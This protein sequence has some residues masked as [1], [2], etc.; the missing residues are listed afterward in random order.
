[1]ERSLIIVV[2]LAFTQLGCASQ[3]VN[4]C[5]YEAGSDARLTGAE[6]TL[7][8]SHPPKEFFG[9][10]W[11]ERIDIPELKTG[12]FTFSYPLEAGLQSSVSVFKVGYYPATADLPLKALPETYNLSVSLKPKRKPISLIAF[13]W[14]GEDVKLAYK[15]NK[16][17]KQ[18]DCLKADWL[19]PDGEGL[20]ADMEFSL[21]RYRKGTK[22]YA[23]FSIRFTNPYDGFEE[24]REYYA[25][26]MRIREAPTT[27]NLQNQL[28]FIEE[29]H[30]GF[31]THFP[32]LKNYAFRVRTQRTP[33]GELLSAYY[34]KLYN[35][36]TFNYVKDYWACDFEYYLNPTPNDRNLE[37]NGHSVNRPRERIN[38]IR[39][40]R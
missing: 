28:D 25:D 14:C 3:N 4:L 9:S 13:N 39:H 5:V 1:M 22:T 20:K 35:A 19:P 26:R 32:Q 18:Y 24:V 30:D 23:W 12:V 15:E 36:F 34:G 8:V 21:Q 29:L 11:D 16:H 37:Y 7:Y 10:R 6:V 27:P 17:I 33:S 2:F 40:V 31:P 38:E